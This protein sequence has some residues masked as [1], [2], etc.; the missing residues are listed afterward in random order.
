MGMKYLMR[1]ARRLPSPVP[2]AAKLRPA[3]PSRSPLAEA[4]Q[5]LNI[6][7]FAEHFDVPV[8][9]EKTEP[10]GDEPLASGA[11]ERPG[12]V[13]SERSP[14][15]MGE[16]RI[17][18]AELG[19][20]AVRGATE[21]ESARANPAGEPPRQASPPSA[22]RL[23]GPRTQAAAGDPGTPVA[24]KPIPSPDRRVAGP[25][26]RRAK[27]LPDPGAAEG[28][29]PAPGSVHMES[30]SAAAREPAPQRER[31]ADP[32]MD[33]LSRAMRWVEGQSR[34]S[35]HEERG[36]HRKDSPSQRPQPRLGEMVEARPLRAAP[37]DLPPVTHLE[38]GRIE[39]EVAAPVKSAQG[40]AAPRPRPKAA[41]S[42]SAS[43]RA[44]GWR[45]R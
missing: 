6:D 1:A 35:P 43:R 2:G 12:S 11:S 40:A 41:G 42:R 19:I 5:R 26:S 13:G 32:T 36:E 28:R 29:R 8:A 18:P 34:N 38:I 3:M 20:P 23:K 7:W 33:A 4:D 14:S 27:S 31:A 15:P 25:P 45:Q 37:R 17:A 24:E 9:R 21:S 39:I 30:A 22:A 44:F 16:P 10:V